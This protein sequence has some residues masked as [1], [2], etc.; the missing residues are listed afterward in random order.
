[1]FNFR[2]L[3]ARTVLDLGVQGGPSDNIPKCVSWA[4]L[5]SSRIYADLSIYQTKPDSSVQA[6]ARVIKSSPRVLLGTA[7]VI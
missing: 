4:P 6:G 3:F 1:M 2:S 5:A 7:G